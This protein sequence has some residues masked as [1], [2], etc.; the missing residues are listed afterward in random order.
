MAGVDWRALEAKE[1][2]PPFKPAVESD[3]SVASFDP[4]FTSADVRAFGE[5][6]ALDVLEGFSFSPPP[7][8]EVSGLPK[9]DLVLLGVI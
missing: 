2:E 3:E 6:A 5:E 8:L 9:P 1:V 4:K 7:E